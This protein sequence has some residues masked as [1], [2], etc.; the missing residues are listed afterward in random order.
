[1]N[2]DSV[3]RVVTRAELVAAGYVDNEIAAAVRR[4]ELRAI[5]RGIYAPPTIADLPRDKRYPHLVRSVAATMPPGR[6]VAS[7]SAAALHG[8]PL[9]G[10]D[11]RR[12][13]TVEAGG[14]SGTR[15]T[16]TAV[17]HRDHRPMALVDIDGVSVVSA[18]RTVVDSARQCGRD[19]AVVVGDAALEKTLCT[20][21][22]IGRE[23]GLIESTPGCVAA[24][25]AVRLMD[26]RGES[27][28]ESRSRLAMLDAELPNARPP[29]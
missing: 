27:V 19:V 18:A 6:A 13:H 28:L 29:A 14:G 10:L 23:L 17:L 25:R 11:L 24:R 7:V 2:I 12:V 3:M 9:W 15:E 16:K 5:G 20:P 26:G 21:D 1:M 8:L 22:D 4:D